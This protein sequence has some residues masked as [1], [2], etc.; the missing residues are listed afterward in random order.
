MVEHQRKRIKEQEKVI[1]HLMARLGPAPAKEVEEVERMAV[2]RLPSLQEAV[3]L[4]TSSMDLSTSSMEAA[5]S[6][7]TSLDLAT[8]P[9]EQVDGD[10]AIHLDS[11]YDSLRGP[12]GVARSPPGVA[13]SP[14]GVARQ[15]GRQAGVARHLQRS[16]SDVVVRRRPGGQ[17]HLSPFSTP[18]YRGFLLRHQRRQRPPL[19]PTPGPDTV[20]V[21]VRQAA[22]QRSQTPRMV[23]SRCRRQKTT[24]FI[25]S[26]E[27]RRS[28]DQGEGEEGGTRRRETTS[29]G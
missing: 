21:A 27:D 29:D 18:L 26:S 15:A 25:N 8:C 10:S 12:P 20:C 6:R 4:T 13:R 23:K 16:V 5:T 7:G 3:E 14:P 24:I 9:G 2:A 28:S 17:G 1:A 22:S 19:S 11:T